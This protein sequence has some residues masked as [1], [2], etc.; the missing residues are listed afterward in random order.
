MNY[1]GGLSCNK[2]QGENKS[3]GNPHIYRKGKIGKVQSECLPTRFNPSNFCIQE[4]GLL[5][6]L[7][8]TRL[9]SKTRLI[10]IWRFKGKVS[11]ERYTDR[12]HMGIT[13]VTLIPITRGI[14]S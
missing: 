4:P 13:L 1:Q 8:Y 2:N 9:K 14:G 10:G 3:Q 5:D 6:Q 7:E 11:M 12:S